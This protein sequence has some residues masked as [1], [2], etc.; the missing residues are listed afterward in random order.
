MITI[1]EF[2][3]Y[4]IDRKGNVYSWKSGELK[5]LKG[6]P[7]TNGYLRVCLCQNG[8]QYDYLIHRLVAQCFIDKVLG[9]DDINHKNGI[10]TDNNVENLEWSNKTLN[11]IHS[12]D[13]LGNHK[14]SMRKLSEYEILLIR[15]SE[16]PQR[17]IAKEFKVSQCTISRVK[18]KTI[19]KEI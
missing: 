14:Y 18:N 13:V 12:Y 1:P 9:L 11:A 7:N 10:V 19:Y 4:E 6:R 15:N 8:G 16:D 17:K 5:K 2:E 3:D